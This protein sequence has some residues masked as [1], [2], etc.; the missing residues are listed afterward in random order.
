M[1]GN[2]VNILISPVNKSESHFSYFDRIAIKKEVGEINTWSHLVN[3]TS[4]K[5]GTYN[6]RTFLDP[7]FRAFTQQNFSFRDGS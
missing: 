1:Y 3:T 6:V 5:K 2:N 7:D 4:W